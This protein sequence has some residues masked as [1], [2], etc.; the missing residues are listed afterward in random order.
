MQQILFTRPKGRRA[1][2]APGSLECPSLATPW[3]IHHPRGS[4]Q[5]PGTLDTIFPI[6]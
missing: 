6:A 1:A 3:D 5:D 2:W 4:V